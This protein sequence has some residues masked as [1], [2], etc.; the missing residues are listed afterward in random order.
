MAS[1]TAWSGAG[2]TSTFGRSTSRSNAVSTEAP[3]ISG[4]CA[5]AMVVAP[6]ARTSSTDVPEASAGEAGEV[7]GVASRLVG[8][9]ADALAAG[10]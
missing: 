10:P 3:V 5:E 1:S 6:N 2:G 9:V 8:V 7:V 4:L